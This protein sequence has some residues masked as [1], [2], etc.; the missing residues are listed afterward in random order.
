MLIEKL[1]CESICLLSSHYAALSVNMT[2]EE[3]FHREF[4]VLS[5]FLLLFS[6]LCC[7][8]DNKVRKDK[9]RLSSCVLQK[10]SVMMWQHHIPTLWSCCFSQKQQVL[11]IPRQSRRQRGSA[12]CVVNLSPMEMCSLWNELCGPASAE[13][14]QWL[15]PH[16]ITACP[17]VEWSDSQRSSSGTNYTTTKWKLSDPL[18]CT[19]SSLHYLQL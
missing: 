17:N 4:L 2:P 3:N 15:T 19:Y 13:K 8:G 14:S 9:S 11:L 6:P 12:G 7:E 5:F 10:A 16:P 18:C 1:R